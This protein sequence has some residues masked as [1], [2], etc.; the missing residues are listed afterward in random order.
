MYKVKYN[1][2]GFVERFKIRLFFLRHKQFAG[3]DYNEKFSPLAK[4]VT[5]CLF[6]AIVVARN[7]ELYEM[8]IQ[9][10]FFYGDLDKEIYMK[11]LSKFEAAFPSKVCRLRK[12]IYGLRQSPRNWFKKLTAALKKFGFTQSYAEYSLFSYVHDN[13]AIHVLVYVDDFVIT[14]SSHEVIQNFKSYL[15]QCFYYFI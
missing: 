3:I 4:M 14:G 6:F 5:F 2:D 10:A 11:M 8:D 12:S 1:C 13:M 7:W 15:S 9:N